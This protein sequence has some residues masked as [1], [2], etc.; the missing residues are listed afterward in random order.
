MKWY[1]PDMFL[2]IWFSFQGHEFV[3]V[4]CSTTTVGGSENGLFH[5]VLRR[6]EKQYYQCRCT[7]KAPGKKLGA[8]QLDCNIHYRECPVQGERCIYKTEIQ[9]MIDI[10]DIDIDIVVETFWVAAK[11]VSALSKKK[12]KESD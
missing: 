12:S 2:L 4:S 10:D 5:K 1:V 8:M 6:D 7:G 3:D 11:E 9:P